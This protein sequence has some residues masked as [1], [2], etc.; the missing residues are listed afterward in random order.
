[1]YVCRYTFAC[2]LY[3]GVISVK[4]TNYCI[5]VSSFSQYKNI[6]KLQ[7]GTAA[8]I[9]WTL[10]SPKMEKA[11]M[12]IGNLYRKLM[13]KFGNTLSSGRAW[14]WKINLLQMI[15]LLMMV[16]LHSY[17]ILPKSIVNHFR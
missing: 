11:A 13:M 3:E 10:D 5:G 12:A 9:A 6:N 16:I 2:R 15:C 1:M 17:V 14:L 4:Q 7:C 8:V